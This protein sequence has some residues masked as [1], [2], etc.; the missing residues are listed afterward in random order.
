[1]IIVQIKKLIKPFVY[2]FLM[3]LPEATL[4]CVSNS[5]FSHPI[6]ENDVDILPSDPPLGRLHHRIQQCFML[7]RFPELN[8]VLCLIRADS[9]MGVGCLQPIDVMCQATVCVSQNLRCMQTE[10]RIETVID[11]TGDSYA[12]AIIDVAREY[13]RHIRLP[14]QVYLTQQ[15]VEQALYIGRELE[16]GSKED[17]CF[18]VG[19]DTTILCNRFNILP[20]PGR[21]MSVAKVVLRVRFLP[22]AFEPVANAASPD[23]HVTRISLAD[24]AE[25]VL[26]HAG[27]DHQD[28]R[29]SL[30]SQWRKVLA[31]ATVGTPS[32]SSY[33]L[34][35][36]SAVRKSQADASG[37]QARGLVAHMAQTEKRFGDPGCG[38]GGSLFIDTA[39]NMAMGAGSKAPPQRFVCNPHRVN[40][41]FTVSRYI[42]ES[43][44]EGRPTLIVCPP[45]IL[46]SWLHSLSR[47][48]VRS[49]VKY[50]GS[51]R[52]KEAKALY[53]AQAVVTTYK[54]IQS[55]MRKAPTPLLELEWHRIVLDDCEAI[56][57]PTCSS[58]V[59]ACEMA[60]ATH[61]WCFSER[62]HLLSA[63]DIVNGLLFLEGPSDRS[64]AERRKQLLQETNGADACIAVSM[65]MRGC[66]TPRQAIKTR[67]PA[68]LGVWIL[69]TF[70]LENSDTTQ[71]DT[72]ERLKTKHVRPCA[73]EQCAFDT[74][75]ALLLGESGPLLASEGSLIQEALAVGTNAYAD[76]L[77]EFREATLN[78]LRSVRCLFRVRKN[79][80]AAET[81]P[82]TPPEPCNICF[83]DIVA[84]VTL[85]CKHFFCYSCLRRMSAN[86]FKIRC[87]L[88]RSVCV[89]PYCELRLP[90]VPARNKDEPFCPEKFLM[91][92][93]VVRP[94]SDEGLCIV[95][96]QDIVNANRAAQFLKR[97]RLRA[98]TRIADAEGVKKK[99]VVLVTTYA[100]LQCK[101]S[102]RVGCIQPVLVVFAEASAGQQMEKEISSL[103][104]D[105]PPELV[106]LMNSEEKRLAGMPARITARGRLVPGGGERSFW[107][108]EEGEELS[109]EA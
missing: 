57:R 3:N 91:V 66:S 83:E 37:A 21:V 14:E 81:Q 1:M 74:V 62:P 13:R 92:Q 51:R 43:Y 16:K 25:F 89:E 24:V 28:F 84:R 4:Y 33:D 59:W 93:T 50:H 39:R 106:G 73:Y 29:L 101:R 68:L 90:D 32:V 55:E 5:V 60:K 64:L 45:S 94:R 19:D 65:R 20:D 52:P 108:R 79:D 47:S 54:I 61:R 7:S 53:A 30:R 9:L 27:P 100:N 31:A 107:C 35:L 36:L 2:Y 70:F 41:L 56:R 98:T 86:S 97:Q 76:P 17:Y 26:S 88:C 11:P 71:T 10:M 99:P 46:T 82:C 103:F 8:R 104:G 12:A 67:S 80:E 38:E 34:Q 105:S 49:A 95:L 18:D 87:P 42:L 72:L 78:H 48:G 63:L 77:K 102:F 40:T 109:T 15:Q 85:P 22:H 58:A 44:R 6:I 75:R 69:R 23:T 96:F